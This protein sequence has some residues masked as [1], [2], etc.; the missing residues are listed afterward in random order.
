RFLGRGR[1]VADPA[2]LDAASGQLSGAAGPVL[3]PV[4]SL[5]RSFRVK[6]GASVSIAFTTALADSRDQAAALAD[7][8]HNFHGVNRAFELAWAHSQVELR[9]LHVSAAEVHLFQ[10]LAGHVLFAGADLRARVSV[11][12]A[13]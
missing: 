9:Q 1:T 11:I 10:R 3:D 13:N 8:Y 6:G 5:R 12:T 2:A 7:H 4:F